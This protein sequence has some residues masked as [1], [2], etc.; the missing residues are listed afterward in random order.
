MRGCFRGDIH[1][2]N[3]G[4]AR[5]RGC[6]FEHDGGKLVEG[7]HRLVTRADFG[8]TQVVE[9]GV[10]RFLVAARRVFVWFGKLRGDGRGYVPTTRKPLGDDCWI[11]RLHGHSRSH[12]R[13]GQDGCSPIPT[14]VG[15]G[16][17]LLGIIFRIVVDGEI[18][19]PCQGLGRDFSRLGPCVQEACYVLRCHPQ[20]II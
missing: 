3:L 6:G 14:G 18:G 17:E 8:F 11:P 7:K 4:G 15:E 19:N 5:C 13:V 9:V 1:V 12:P 2:D 16:G 20:R 10:F